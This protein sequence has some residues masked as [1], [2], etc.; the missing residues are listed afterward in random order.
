MAEEYSNPNAGCDEI[1]T[2]V[3]ESPDRGLKDRDNEHPTRRDCIKFGAGA[4][5]ATTG[6]AA[7]GTSSAS[8]GL[9]TVAGVTFDREVDV[10]DDLGVDPNGSGDL[11]NVLSGSIPAGTL[12]RFPAGTYRISSTIYVNNDRVGFV[13]DGDATVKMASGFK[14]RFLI[15]N[16]VDKMVWKGVDVDMRGD[17]RGDIR[18]IAPTHFHFEDVEFL[19]RGG[20]T[21]HALAVEVNDPDGEATIKDV[22]I[23]HGGYMDRYDNSTGENGDG[24]IGIW[25]GRNHYGVLHVENVDIRE[26]GNN[27]MYTSRCPGDI[28][29]SNSYFENNNVSS[30]RISGDGSWVENSTFV[31]DHDRY[32]PELTSTESGF[33]TRPI[34]IEQ[35]KGLTTDEFPAKPAG[36]EVRNCTVK[37]LSSHNNR[38]VAGGINQGPQAR[39]L[40]VKDTDIRVD[41]PGV[42]AIRRNIP[43]AIPWRT[44]QSVPPKPH[45]TRVDGVTITGSATGGEAIRLR[46][47]DDSVIRATC[48]NQPNTGRDGIYVEDTQNA[49]VQYSM[50]KVGGEPI[51]AK[52]C[53]VSTFGVCEDTRCSCELPLQTE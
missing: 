47:A 9:R 12:I 39:S 25:A 33:N 26:F 44:D 7:A 16:E 18:L 42:P 35:G 37:V 51:M 3:S 21:G 50:I 4:A 30:V 34:I 46:Q 45:W 49:H 24:R 10:V 52:Y 22:T 13:A 2:D 17:A 5:A 23:K 6:I 38:H 29:V 40:T 53:N 32:E 41:V 15:Q 28:R 19:G 27:G 14:D 20:V 31:I 8:T 1:D 11:G 48:I 36:C 43:G